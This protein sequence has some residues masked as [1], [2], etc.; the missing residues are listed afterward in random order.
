[1]RVLTLAR[2][3]FGSAAASRSRSDLEVSTAPRAL[4]QLDAFFFFVTGEM[5]D[6]LNG[7]GNTEIEW[8]QNEYRSAGFRVRLYGG[9]AAVAH[10]IVKM[11]EWVAI[12][13]KAFN[14]LV[15]KYGMIG[16]IVFVW[17]K[18]GNS[19]NLKKICEP[20]R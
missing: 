8:T 6:H 5:R 20:T 4:K 15:A 3:E 16:S 10:K 1:V 7:N 13:N 2:T 17:F 18:I 12:K 19:Q 9:P 11:R 14:E